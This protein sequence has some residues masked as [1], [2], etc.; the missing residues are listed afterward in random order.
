[1]DIP[2]SEEDARAHIAEIRAS[3]GQDNAES[4]VADLENALFILADQLYQKSTH[5]LLELIQNAD[6]NNYRSSNPTLN[7]T[8]SGRTLRIDCNEIGFTRRNTEAICKVGRS[9]KAGLDK[10]TEY[11]GEKGIGFKSVFKIADFVWIHSGHYSFMFDKNTKLGMI[12]PI[13]TA[14]PCPPKAGYTSMYLQ[15]TDDCNVR[16][17][18]NEIKSLDPRLLIFLRKLREVNITFHEEASLTWETKLTCQNV[19]T[20]NGE[21][22]VKLHQDED[23]RLYKIIRHSIL[24]LPP[25][26]KR[27]NCYESQIFLAFLLGEFEGTSMASQN[28]YAFLP[29]RDYGFKFLIQADFLLSA[30]REEIDASSPW[31]QV[32]LENTPKAFR[33]AV[34]DFNS[35]DLRYTWIK[36]LQKRSPF[37]GFF[38]S[39]EESIVQALS[40]SPI[41]ESQSGELMVPSKL[42]TVPAAVL[43]DDEQPFV[44]TDLSGSKYISPKYSLEKHRAE[45]SLLG[46]KDVT[47]EE[48]VDDLEMFIK[49]S[50]ERFQ[51]MPQIWHSRLCK[52]L[53]Q[54]SDGNATVKEKAVELEIIPLSGG[55]WISSSKQ[56]LYFSDEKNKDVQIPNGIEMKEIN[57]EAASDHS[58][59]NLYTL[60]GARV[61]TNE[62]VC[63]A[64]ISTHSSSSFLPMLLSL[65]D[66]ISHAM[67]LFHA[68]WTR[69]SPGC[70]WLL[71][72]SGAV[73]PSFDAYIDSDKTGSAS[74]LFGQDRKLFSFIHSDY[75]MKVALDRQSQLR[76]WMVA[77]LGVAE[78]PRLVDNW[79]HYA[80]WITQEKKSTMECTRQVRQAIGNMSVSCKGGGSAKL[81]ETILPTPN[82]DATSLAS[83]SFLEIPDPQHPQWKKLSHFGVVVTAGI[84][85]FIKYL[86]ILKNSDSTLEKT[87]ELYK[88]IYTQCNLDPSLIRQCKR[89]FE[90]ETLIFTPK[91]K[92]WTGREWLSLQG[93]VW[94]GPT[95][96]RKVACLSKFYP[97]HYSFFSLMLGLRKA[98]WTTLTDEARMIKASDPLDYISEVFVA[99]SEHFQ[100]AVKPRFS[101]ARTIIAALTKSAIFP[102]DEGKSGSTFDYLSTS[103]TDTT[104]YIADRP[105]L[106]HVFQGHVPLL[107]LN[108]ETLGKI[109][110]LIKA[111]SWDRRLLSRLA[112][113]VP[114]VG[115]DAQLNNKYTRS[116]CTRA[117]FIARLMPPM[118]A[119]R[120][121]IIEQLCNSKVYT[122]KKITL[123]WTVKVRDRGDVE[124]R[125][126]SGDSDISHPPLELLEELADFCQ[127]TEASQIALLHASG[128]ASR[129]HGDADYWEDQE[130]T[131]DAV[132]TFMNRFTAL[133]QWDNAKARPW[134]TTNT[135][136]ILPHFYRLENVDPYSLLPQTSRSLWSGRLRQ[137]GAFLDDQTSISFIH[138]SSDSG[139]KSRLRPHRLFPALVTINR[140]RET[141][142]EMLPDS[143]V[144]VARDVILAGE[145]YVSKL[146]ESELREVYDPEIHWT[147]SLRQ[148]TGLSPFTGNEIEASTFTIADQNGS[149]ALSHMLARKVHSHRIVNKNLRAPVY[150]IEVVT[151][152]GG[153]TSVIKKNHVNVILLD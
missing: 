80:K 37:S 15:L 135:D 9:T 59:R 64:I 118:L 153:I 84:G 65:E 12:T 133:N 76:D 41:L 110:P 70:L 93:C 26:P 66:L 56:V 3:K 140:A 28:V 124:G 74:T 10:S 20:T 14:F 23:C 68:N 86:E 22:L 149:L 100:A 49:S 8:L 125:A 32:L 131:F 115:R 123:K 45:L 2:Q 152:A 30:S 104:W 151:T 120:K 116:M 121:A 143:T 117:R 111:L 69:I 108:E 11:I 44:P 101:E 150:H 79:D 112:R 24:D 147:S 75:S 62:K 38:S 109:D 126:D 77:N 96:L 25:E 138:D 136:S 85:P 53:Y 18:L 99:I 102:V 107:A 94:E 55:K 129:H 27:P 95:C 1:M 5:F 89:S 71:T 46:V 82:T 148:K 127:L 52:L 13:W 42:R 139:K 33:K 29:I 21:E 72:E 91:S 39:L 58:R 61:W 35:G 90:S 134:S 40:D 51:N 6:D 47:R 50:P 60:L 16:E 78:F 19:G 119:N 128:S 17:L 132:S 97:E 122:V 87:S 48:F 114:D 57:F 67:F 88:Q 141:V 146:L 36:F 31:N 54:F 73:K 105:H 98:D 145:V 83:I 4:D 43:G 103:Q 142:V 113:G 92:D 81:R 130:A 144:D 7:I 63:Q 34:G 106:K 137:A